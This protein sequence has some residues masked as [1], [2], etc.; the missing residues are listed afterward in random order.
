MYQHDKPSWTVK[1]D[2]GGGYI[3]TKG[4]NG[5]QYTEEE[6]RKEFERQMNLIGPNGLPMI[7][8]GKIV[9]IT[10]RDNFKPLP[11]IVTMPQALQLANT[12]GV[13]LIDDDDE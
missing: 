2:M 1:I 5:P 3:S 9:S 8:K 12:P 4:I 13:E 6:V 10:P 11:P 7:P